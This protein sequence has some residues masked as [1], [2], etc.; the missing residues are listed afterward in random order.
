MWLGPGRET[1]NAAFS[2]FHPYYPCNEKDER[3]RAFPR[4]VAFLISRAFR[5]L[6]AGTVYDTVSTT[7][8]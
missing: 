5:D 8:T 3:R 2:D 4:L 7:L 6:N 1:I